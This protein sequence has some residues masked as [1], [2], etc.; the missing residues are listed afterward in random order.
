MY[1]NVKEEKIAL[2]SNEPN[3]CERVCLWNAINSIWHRVCYE[4]QNEQ[5][6]FLDWAHLVDIKSNEKGTR[7]KKTLKDSKKSSQ[8]SVKLHA[9]PISI[10]SLC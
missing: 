7:E 8:N 1:W 4:L 9:Q 3:K 6:F 10:E 2:I 5:F